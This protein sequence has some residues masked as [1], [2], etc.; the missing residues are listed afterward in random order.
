MCCCQKTEQLQTAE[1]NRQAVGAVVDMSDCTDCS[2]QST[3]VPNYFDNPLLNNPKA[4]PIVRSDYEQMWDLL[5]ANPSGILIKTVPRTIPSISYD[6]AKAWLKALALAEYVLVDDISAMNAVC[7]TYR[8]IL[9]RDIGQQPPR[10]DSKG[11]VKPPQS[12]D[13]IW[14]TLRILKNGN[15]HQIVS[16]GSTPEVALQISHVRQYLQALYKAGYLKAMPLRHPR[17][18]ASYQ[19]I[20]NTGPKAPQIQRGKKVYDANLGLVVYDPENALPPTHRQEVAQSEQKQ[21]AKKLAKQAAKQKTLEV[22]H[23]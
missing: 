19:L 14:R 10:I 4:T 21:A 8:Y 3:T 13:L 17:A 16:S 23:V 7:A 22:R 1:N 6:K 11:Q 20:K 18:L 12:N 5:R 2:K 9:V 15:A